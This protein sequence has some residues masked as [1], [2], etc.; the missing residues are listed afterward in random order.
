MYRIEVASGEET[1]FRTIEEL[2]VGI[3]NGVVTPRSRIYHNASQKWL[4]IGL[5]PHYKKALELPAASAAHPTTPTPVPS[6]PRLRPRAEAQ[7]TP[8]P[9][10]APEPGPL[11]KPA[12]ETAS[13]PKVPAPM[14]SP[15]VAMQQEVLRDLPVVVIPEPLPWSTRPAPAEPAQRPR[16]V[17]DVPSAPLTYLPNPHA[18]RIAPTPFSRPAPEVQAQ[19]TATVT[20]TPLRFAEPAT[21]PAHYEPEE[22]TPARPTARRSRRAGGRPLLLLGVAA[23]VVL[24]AH[25]T[26]TARPSAPADAS[27]AAE[28]AD[29]PPEPVVSD[30]AAEEPVKS[31]TR[32]AAVAPAEPPP[33]V[34]SAPARVP[35]TP[36]PAF[37]GS[38]PARPGTGPAFTPRA[39]PPAAAPP[40][41]ASA[42]EGSIAPAPV[43]VDLALPDLPPDSVVPAARRG[44]TTAMKKILRALNG[45]KQEAPAAP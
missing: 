11:P 38:V 24:A 8:R 45:T 14:M 1:V 21:G 26:L 37:S 29:A 36:G 40:S 33:R 28:P 34:S 41:D 2:A 44:D 43:A 12:T 18:E 4:P 39:T 35:M 20:Y 7:P 32:A 19:P 27:D 13:E 5:H 9:V 22:P 42:P 16:D 25:F 23:A 3:R 6:V 30:L 31:R 17:P 15:V 10:P